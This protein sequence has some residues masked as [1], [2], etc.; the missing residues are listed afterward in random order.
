[1]L[2]AELEAVEPLVELVELLDL[3]LVERVDLVDLLL[4]ELVELLVELGVR[5][6]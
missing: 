4:V 2:L 1:M 3:P 6:C 5:T